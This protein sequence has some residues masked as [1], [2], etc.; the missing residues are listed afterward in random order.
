MPI[1]KKDSRYVAIAYELMCGFERATALAK[2]VYERLKPDEGFCNA[3]DDTRGWDGP[4]MAV[5]VVTYRT[6]DDATRLDARVR[7]LLSR[8]VDFSYEPHLHTS[9]GGRGPTSYVT[10][11]THIM[12]KAA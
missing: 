7:S 6:L 5:V 12:E 11:T 2:D 3:E 4:Y 10:A 9:Y 8:N 1:V